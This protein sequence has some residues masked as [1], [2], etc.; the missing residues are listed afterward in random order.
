[1]PKKVKLTANI[2]FS[3]IG[4]QERGIQNTGL[5]DLD[6]LSTSEINKEAV[7]AY[8]AIH[9]GLT[10]EM[11][12]TYKGY[13]SMD[14]MRAELT[15]INLGYIPEKKLKYDWYKE[16]KAQEQLTKKCWLA[17]KLNRNLGD[18]SLID[19]L[20]EADLWTLS[21]PCT[22]ISIAGRLQGLDP[23]DETRSS[24]IWQNIRLL[25]T[26][27]NTG[28]LPKYLFLENVKNLAGKRF[29]ASFDQFNDLIADFGYNVYWQIIN[30]KDCGIPQNRERVYAIYIR[31]DIDTGHFTFPKPFDN[32][33]RLKDVLEGKVAEKYYVNT[34][35]AQE[36]I[37]KLMADNDFLSGDHNDTNRI[38]QLGNVMVTGKRENPN[39]GRV[40][41]TNYI[42]PTIGKM[43]GGGRQPHIVKVGDGSERI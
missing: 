41:D 6:V 10:N 13:P 26:A 36:L 33:M 12:D 5:F 35:K 14:V 34:E 9:H 18:I 15:R 25:R 43:E 19:V 4:C 20:P 39:Q 23:D 37:D 27:K 16:G 30:G 21:A 31:K 7:I 2:L 3:G 40:Y 1:M 11:V 38:K 8:A 42:A 24:L 17:C 22:D 29:R 28:T 32:G